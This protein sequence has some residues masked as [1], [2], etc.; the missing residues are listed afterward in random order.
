MKWK[1]IIVVALISATAA[2]LKIQNTRIESVTAERD[3]VQQQLVNQR[4]KTQALM[5]ELSNQTLI[6]QQQQ[7]QLKVVMAAHNS[8]VKRNYELEQ[9]HAQASQ[10]L[11]KLRQQNKEMA[12]WSDNPIPA[13][14]D[15]WLRYL[16]AGASSDNQAADDQPAATAQRADKTDTGTGTAGSPDNP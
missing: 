16:S 8:A 10:Q 15:N 13:A 12:E 7:Q 4:D 1:I 6:I 11:Q 3:L 9:Q 5:Q 14:A 2:A